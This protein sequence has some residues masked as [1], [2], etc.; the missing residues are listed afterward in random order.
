[1]RHL[2]DTIRARFKG[3]RC[4]PGDVCWVRENVTH[5]VWRQ[6]II[7]RG[8]TVVRVTR[9]S[10]RGLW[11]LDRPVK[12]TIGFAG[13]LIASGEVVAMADELLI[14]LRDK[15]GEDETLVAKPIERQPAQPVRQPAEVS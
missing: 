5:P 9:L 1:M 8:G 2:F 13:L 3:L 14:P 10:E 11:V 12:F 4:R 6:W 15:P 7:V